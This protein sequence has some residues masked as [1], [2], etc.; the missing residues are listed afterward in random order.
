MVLGF[1]NLC[2]PALGC[3]IHWAWIQVQ[4]IADE[5]LMLSMK[6]MELNFIIMLFKTQLERLIF[7][8]TRHLLQ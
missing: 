3:W 6:T 1:Y 2:G 8:K 5:W 4:V 7:L